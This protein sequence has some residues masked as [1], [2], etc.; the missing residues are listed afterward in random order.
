MQIA[1]WGYPVF[2][3]DTVFFYAQTDEYAEFSNFAPYGVAL[4][5]A[6]WPTVEHYF[7]AQ[8]FADQTYRE[9]IRRVGKPKEAKALGMTRHL[10]LRPDWEEVK[11]GVML[12]AVRTKFVT[13]KKLADLLL[14]TG[15]RMIAE[16]APMDAYWGIGP[17]GAGLNKLGKI[18]MKVR[19]E[20][21]K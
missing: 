11:D 5:G 10:P 16:N 17:D 6:W 3:Q 8:K 20:L 2:P 7:Q 14:S 12:E 15:E 19:E 18:L 13:H 4:E 1:N 9:K 21:R